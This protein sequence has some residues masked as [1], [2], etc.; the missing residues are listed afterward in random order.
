MSNLLDKASIILT[1]TAYNNGE[2][3]CVKPSDGS[4]DFDFSRNSAATRVNAQGLVENVQILSSNLVQNGDFSEEGVQEVSNGSFSQEGAELVTNGDF[5]TDS[6]WNKGSGW[7][8]SGGKATSDGTQVSASYLSQTLSGISQG[9]QYITEFDIDVISGSF[10]FNTLGNNLIVTESGH[11]V[12]YSTSVSGITLYLEAQVGFTGSIDNVSVREVGQDWTLGTGWSIGE[13]KAV[14]V[15][16]TASK[17][18]QTNT[19]NGKTC[20]VTLT[21]SDYSS[22]LLQ[23]DFGSTSSASIIANGDYVFYGTYDQNNFEIYKSS[24]FIG[25]ITNIS[26]KEVGQN[27]SVSNSDAN[28]YVEFGDGTARLKFLNVSPITQLMAT[29]PYVSG[30]KYKLIVDVASVTSG[31]IKV[32]NAGIDETFDTVGISTRIINPTGTSN[33]EF[34]RASADVDITLNSVSL[35]EI[36]DDT[37]LPRINYEGFSYQDALGSELVVNGGFDSGS[38]WGLGTNWS[39]SGGNL[40]STN[41]AQYVSANQNI[42]GIT[43]GKTYQINI[44]V[45]STSG[46]YI[47]KVGS[48]GSIYALSLGLNTI[49]AVWNGINNGLAIYNNAS[50]TGNISIDNVSVKEYLGQSVVP[51]SGCGSWLFEPQSTNL[52]TYSE[53]FSNAYWI[54]SGASVVSGFSSPDGSLNASLL[55]GDGLGSFPRIQT[56]VS[57]SGQISFSVFVK[58]ELSDNV[59]IYISGTGIGGGAEASSVYKYT[60]STDSFLIT[61]GGTVNSS[62]STSFGNDWVRLTLNYTTTTITGVRIYPKYASTSTDGVYIYGAQLEEQTYATSYIPTSGSTVTRNQDVC[63]NG[64]SLA[65]INSTEG[66]LY[67]EVAALADTITDRHIVSISD[68]TTSNRVYIGFG[69]ASNLIEGRSRIAGVNAGFTDFVV[70]DET[71]FHKI[72]Y[73]WKLNDY[74]LWVDGVEVDTSTGA[75]ASANTLNTLNFNNGV[76]ANIAEGKVKAVAVWKEALS[77]QELAELTTI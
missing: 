55:K 52:I 39:I 75:V 63:T 10:R 20:K 30:K 42:S 24:D 62:V 22:G 41:S 37:S 48:S 38:D 66:V 59:T 58:K 57:G 60:F 36:T 14:A 28:N 4:G 70:S 54:K 77:D 6:N 35:I 27:W 21:V 2:A 7:S 68:G 65:S 5:A 43:L 11:Y 31:S 26:V 49:T 44:N 67:A 8:I 12:I 29:A 9:K 32:A 47:V 23:V 25:S 61:S 40:L 1:P 45:N 33:I 56:T 53:D 18:R 15:S 3:L 51:D 46:G 76:G 19:L 69:N 16:G 13:D 74:S 50:S 64:G 72:A 71:E 34:Y 73:K 17:L